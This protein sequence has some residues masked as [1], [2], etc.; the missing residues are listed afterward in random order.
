MSAVTASIGLELQERKIRKKLRTDDCRGLVVSL[1]HDATP[2]KIA[3]GPLQDKLLPCARYAHKNNDGHWRYLPWNEFRNYTNTA[4]RSGV[5]ELFAVQYTVAWS[6]K[7]GLRYKH[8]IIAPPMLLQAGNASNIHSAIDQCVS[9]LSLESLK[10]IAND[11]RFMML[12]EGP[13]NIAYNKRHCGYTAKEELPINIFYNPLGC[14][15]H[16]FS[17]MGTVMFD[18]DV[19][20]GEVYNLSFICDVTSYHNRLLGTAWD[21]INTEAVIID[22]SLLPVDVEMEE[23][24][25]DVMKH[26]YSRGFTF[27]RARLGEDEGIGEKARQASARLNGTEPI[28]TSE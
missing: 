12:H 20:T 15:A 4:P 16:L 5:V 3:F 13:D 10:K 2:I 19:L 25:Q 26:T 24:R 6:S 23:Y 28:T 11:N 9:T 1:N 21:M 18:E 17:R 27:V 8:K 22:G 14:K 7:Q